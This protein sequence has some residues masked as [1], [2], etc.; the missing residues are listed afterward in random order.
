MKSIT[1]NGTLRAEVGSK[2]AKDTRKEGFVPGVLY[3]GENPIHFTA[4]EREFNKVLYTPSVYLIKLVIDGTEY[5]SIL[6]ATQFHPVKDNLLHVDF[7]E[8]TADKPIKVSL[9]VKTLGTAIGVRNGGRLGVPKKKVKVSGL[10]GDM[11]DDIEINVEKLRI[12]R[13]V[14][15]GD[16]NIPGITFLEDPK[17]EVCG[18]K[19]KRGAIDADEDEE[20]EGEETAATEGAEA[21]AEA[22]PENAAE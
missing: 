3:G 12:G 16:L 8:V 1:I 4:D 19:A 20:E 18:V 11:P 7:L 13:S 14:R 17:L 6:Q 10:Y 9:P 2:N 5:T 21:T 15:I 22:A